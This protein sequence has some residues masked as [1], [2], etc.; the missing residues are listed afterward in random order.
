MAIVHTRY[1][2]FKKNKIK[3]N[4]TKHEYAFNRSERRIYT[5]HLPSTDISFLAMV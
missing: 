5:A 4:E 3:T 2:L 1:N